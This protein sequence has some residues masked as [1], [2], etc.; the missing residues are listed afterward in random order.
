MTTLLRLHLRTRRGFLI[1]WLAPLIA[2]MAL[3]P[4]AYRATY[5]NPGELELL[6]GPM[7]V[8]LALRAMYGIVPEPFTFGAFAQ[9]EVG[10]WAS[11]LGS[12]MAILLAV[13]LTRAAEDDGIAEVLRSSGL[14]TRTHALSAA[15]VVFGACAA[16]GAGSALALLACSISIE[17]MSAVGCVLTGAVVAASTSA[18]GAVGLLAGNVAAT[19]R[20]A[21][22]LGLAF[23]GVAYAVRA[24]ADVRELD[25]L[26]PASPLGWRD[27]VA[28]YSGDR[29][30]ALLP[31]A[32]AVLALAW[33]A[34]AVAAR[35]DLGATWPVR[36]AGRGA[37]RDAEWRGLGPWRLRARLERPALLGW[38]TA[39]ILLTVFF[40]SMTGEMTSLLES[41]PGTADLARQ[42]TGGATMEDAF[43]EMT[44]VLL[45]VLV[46]CAAVQA[47]LSVRGDEIAGRLAPELAAGVRRRTPHLVAWAVAMTAVTAIL[48]VAAPLGAAAAE[49]SSG[50]PG[51]GSGALW[52]IAGQWPA[53]FAAAGIAIFFAATLPK[54]AWLAWLPVAWSGVASFFGGIFSF[55]DWLLDA[56]LFAHAPHAADGTVDW[57]GSLVLAAIGML[58]MMLGAVAVGKRDLVG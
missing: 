28:P 11:I 13:R 32:A 49:A 5:P 44:A 6:A 52:S 54:V 10:M 55:P 18:A 2:L 20:G 27:V 12:V 46:V 51:V 22:G 24:F 40:M 31:M 39:I 41:S 34:I 47:T 56:S 58:G 29:A 48:A 36:S 3:T 37:R 50:S 23:L 38:A 33:L 21:R 4:P 16:L 30:W 1:A 8:N 9:W 26:R 53:A 42:M 7:R 15:I 25:W 17:G 43:T 14:T 57:T 35:R 45:G 19:A